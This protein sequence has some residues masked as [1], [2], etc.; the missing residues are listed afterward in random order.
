MLGLARTSWESCEACHVKMRPLLATLC[1][2]S[3]SAWQQM[4]S[5]RRIAPRR[6]SVCSAVG[7]DWSARLAQ[8]FSAGTR[9]G[10][11][12]LRAAATARDALEAL[13]PALE[14][15]WDDEDVALVSSGVNINALGECLAPRLYFGRT[16]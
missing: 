12:D 6:R 10:G 4:G 1:L 16:G 9:D 13:K 11:D 8:E 2:W 3:C 5:A 14:G 15:P 7:A